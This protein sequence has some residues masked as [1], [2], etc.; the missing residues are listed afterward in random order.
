MTL[1]QQVFGTAATPG[2][3]V[4]RHR[5]PPDLVLQSPALRQ[6]GHGCAG[7]GARAHAA[8]SPCHT[9]SRRRAERQSASYGGAPGAR[10]SRRSCRTRSMRAASRALAGDAARAPGCQGGCHGGVA[11]APCAGKPCRTQ[12]TRA[13]SRLSGSAGGA[14]GEPASGETCRTRGTT[15]CQGPPGKQGGRGRVPAEL[16]EGCPA[17]AC[18]GA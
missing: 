14:T 5:H 3:R 9:P 10:A 2:P 13:A 11:G 12:G 15:R 4:G 17:P 16:V 1:L 8:R 18:K 7:G 6:P